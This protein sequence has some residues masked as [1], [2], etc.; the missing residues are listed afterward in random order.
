M[1]KFKEKVIKLYSEYSEFEKIITAKNEQLLD[2]KKNIAE[3]VKGKS[4]EEMEEILL[5]LYSDIILYKAHSKTVF[6]EVMLSI[7]TYLELGGGELPE[8]IT[9]FYNAMKQFVP[10]RLFAIEKGE[11]VETEVGLLEE[12]RKLLL[13][14]EYFQALKE[15][16]SAA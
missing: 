11:V 14:G 13:E 12:Q 1:E 9:K 3:I 4:L 8:E 15:K 6:V 16:L 5:Q 7:E 2:N 10:K